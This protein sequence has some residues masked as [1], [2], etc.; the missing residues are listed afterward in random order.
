MAITVNNNVSDGVSYRKSLDTFSYVEVI[1]VEG[2]TGPN[3]ARARKAADRAG[4]SK[5]DSKTKKHPSIRGL[6]ATNVESRAISG[7]DASIFEVT[8]TYEPPLA[9][10]GTSAQE[11]LFEVGAVAIQE[12]TN[13]DVNGKIISVSYTNNSANPPVTTPQNGT[14]SVLKPQVVAR[15][16]FTQTGSPLN[17][18][19]KF[20]GKVNAGTFLRKPGGTWLCTKWT[21]RSVDGGRTFQMEVEFQFNEN[22]WENTDVVFID[23]NTGEPPAD[24][25]NTN[26]ISSVPRYQTVKFPL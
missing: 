8:V 24:V 20:T 1:R 19:L 15:G 14:I 10:E 16:T 3:A 9:E 22:G 7:G 18:S 13:K 12:T 21:G 25:S 5:F 4:F 6:V 26:G 11:T 2:V 17:D 23:T